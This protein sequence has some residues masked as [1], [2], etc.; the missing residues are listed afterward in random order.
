VTG[1]ACNSMIIEVYN[2]EDKFI[3]RL[4]NN[5][6]LIGSYPIDDGA[7]LH[8]IFECCCLFYSAQNMSLGAHVI[9]QVVLLGTDY[10]SI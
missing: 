3:C 7:R 9:M 10:S 2:K 4:D 6:A 1:A 8:V 5:D